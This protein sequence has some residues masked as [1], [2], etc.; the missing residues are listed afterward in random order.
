VE[1]MRLV[2]VR[3]RL[4]GGFVAVC[5]LLIGTTLIG[6]RTASEQQRLAKSIDQLLV[7]TRDMGQVK[8]RISD[9]S[10]WQLSYAW[11][12][13]WLGGRQAVNQ[14]SPS[15]RAF[16][17]SMT[18]LDRELNAVERGPVTGSESELLA[19]VRQLVALYADIDRRAVESFRQDTAEGFRN[20]NSLILGA[21]YETARKIQ[22]TISKL[23][24]SV[25]ERST[26]AQREAADDVALGKQIQLTGSLI[27]LVLASTISWLIT[28][29]I[30]VTVHQIV[31]GLERLVEDESSP[32]LSDTGRDELTDIARAFNRTASLLESAH[33][34]QR[35]LTDRL[36]NLAYRDPLTGLLNRAEF[37]NR[38]EAAVARA[39]TTGECLACLLIDLDDFKPVNDEYGHAAGDLVL[40]EVANR[41]RHQ[42][43]ATDTVARLGGDEFAVFIEG[44]HKDNL[45]DRL[46]ERIEAAVR[47]P[48]SV[49]DHKVIVTASVG[50]GIDCGAHLTANEL[51]EAADVA[52]YTEKRLRKQQ[53]HRTQGTQRHTV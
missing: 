30:V 49:G 35:D 9:I 1:L 8:F 7:L 33:V 47:Q 41:M 53:L 23:V 40:T 43:R 4:I 19:E 10:G 28:R 12:A 20:A 25:S 16:E 46:P 39:R 27:A 26:R 37:F 5:G 45:I 18:A 42:V 44:G 36:R 22:A 32:K 31:G 15:R 29:S 21:S 50:F 34:E 52:M 24:V 38:V 3:L 48:I 13:S 11:E 17:D 6:L 51:L 14:A 2:S